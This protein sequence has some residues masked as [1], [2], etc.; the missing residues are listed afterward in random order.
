MIKTPVK[1]KIMLTLQELSKLEE[2]FMRLIDSYNVNGQLCEMKEHARKMLVY[3]KDL[4][5]FNYEFE[6]GKNSYTLETCTP[7]NSKEDANKTIMQVINKQSSV[8][9]AKNDKVVVDFVRIERTFNP[10]PLYKV[11]IR[12]GKLPDRRDGKYKYLGQLLLQG[13]IKFNSDKEPGQKVYIHEDVPFCLRSRGNEIGKVAKDIRLQSSAAQD[14]SYYTKL[15]VLHEKHDVQL[16]VRKRTGNNSTG[17]LKVEDTD[18]SDVLKNRYASA[19]ETPLQVYIPKGQRQIPPRQTPKQDDGT[20][21]SGASN[22]GSNAPLPQRARNNR[23]IQRASPPVTH[24]DM[25]AGLPTGHHQVNGN[26]TVGVVS[27]TNR[28]LTT[29]TH[30]TRGKGAGTNKVI[31]GIDGKSDL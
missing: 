4:S 27:P 7:I 22:T 14:I 13:Q 10:L 11:K 17:W 12:N 3:Y 24:R 26:V 29:V 18:I 5:R 25:Q 2:H 20:S 19:V 16:M 28:D 21:A 1:V 9:L 30:S 8:T 31:G 15:K 23:C 6:S